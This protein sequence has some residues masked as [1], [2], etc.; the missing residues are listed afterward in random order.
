MPIITISHQIGSGGREIGQAVARSLGL[1]YIDQQ[2]IQGVA[3]Q[4]GIN[5]N[6]ALEM[7]EKAQSTVMR[8]L[9]AVTGGLQTSVVPYVYTGE[10]AAVDEKEYLEATRKVIEAAAVS[11]HAVI[12]G[13]GA[14]FA[15]LGRPSVLNIYLYALKEKRIQT[16]MQRDNLNSSQ[17]AEQVQHND[18]DRAHYVKI[19]YNAEWQNP[20]HYHL[21]LNTGVVKPRLATEIIVQAAQ[22]ADCCY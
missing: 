2:I 20:I 18:H 12:A 22:D 6:V 9:S 7:D 3:K 21:M 16:L 1:D 4:L 19:F 8:V 14:N 5:E 11:N 15:L 17:A 10:N 13:H